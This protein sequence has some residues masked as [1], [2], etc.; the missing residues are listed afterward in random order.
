[1]PVGACPTGEDML[2]LLTHDSHRVIWRQQRSYTTNGRVVATRVG[3]LVAACTSGTPAF[4]G[5]TGPSQI[6]INTTAP[7]V[8]NTAM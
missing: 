8:A 5:A 3:P 4:H 2:V 1:M 7:V 6:A